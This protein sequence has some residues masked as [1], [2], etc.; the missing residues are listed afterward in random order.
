MLG[1]I[2]ILVG[3]GRN[4]EKFRH[5]CMD[6]AHGLEK[7]LVRRVVTLPFACRN[8]DISPAIN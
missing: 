5:E 8:N 2:E 3:N 4:H 7:F 6:L 1:A